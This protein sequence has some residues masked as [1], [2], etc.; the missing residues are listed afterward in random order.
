VQ[1]NT[2]G[3]RKPAVSLTA[4]SQDMQIGVT[5]GRARVLTR[6]LHTFKETEALNWEM[7]LMALVW[8]VIPPDGSKA[9]WQ[10]G[11]MAARPNGSKAQWQQGGYGRNWH[12]HLGVNLRSCWDC[13]RPVAPFVFRQSTL[14]HILVNPLC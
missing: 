12:L 10:Q 6:V 14:P 3:E 4:E 8:K 9:R 5:S 13:M 11:P 7:V 2:S 1:T